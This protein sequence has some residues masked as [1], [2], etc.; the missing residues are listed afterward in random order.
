VLS[1]VPE[2]RTGGRG[3]FFCGPDFV[4]PSGVTMGTEFLPSFFAC[5]IDVNVIWS[6]YF[7]FPLFATSKKTYSVCLASFP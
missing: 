1:V 5:L 4:T 7:D 6:G 3:R 2:S